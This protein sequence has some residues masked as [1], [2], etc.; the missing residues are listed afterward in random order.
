MDFVALFVGVGV[1][2]L[3]GFVIATQLA[4]TRAAALQ[5]TLE[6]KAAELAGISAES[7]ALRT[8]V[9]D[10]SASEAGAR[11]AVSGLESRVQE[12]LAN[13][14]EERQRADQAQR[15]QAEALQHS[16]ALEAKLAER[17]KSV[18]EQRALLEQSKLQ[19]TDTFKATGAELLL[20]TAEDLLKRNKDQF[21]GHKQ[22]SQQ[23]LEARQKSIDAL[24]APLKEQLAKQELLVREL[25]EKR[26]GDS[27]SLAEQLKQIAG[28]QL[29]ASQAANTLSSAMRDNRQRGQWG[30]V[31]LRNVV[32]MAGMTAH[33]DFVE[34]S[35]IDGADGA[36]LRPDMIVRLPGDRVVP[37][38]SKVPM[39][40][41]LDSIDV[42]AS[43]S[44]RLARRAAH[45]SA[46]RTHVRALGSK[47]YASA[48]GGAAEL[49]VMFVPVESALIAALEYDG[50]L[51]KEALD[52]RVVITTPSTLLALLRVCA[53]QWQQASINDNARKIGEN[54]QELLERVRKFA[55]HLQ[56][57]GT[58]LDQ[59]SKAFSAAVGSYNSRL[60]P[61]VRD[62]AALASTLEHEA[63]R[64]LQDVQQSARLD[65]VAPESRAAL[66]DGS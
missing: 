58:N 52:A 3:A 47:D 66:S 32:E 59:A 31:G 38:D 29:Q 42:N 60:V 50:S 16:G 25:G 40:A 6:S 22:L 30:E 33:V 56:R 14:A 9:T 63:A 36:R 4:R 5:A 10:L 19:L 46:L 7:A 55:E 1:G 34:Q 35:S 54:A 24:V 12:L 57:V 62:T 37:I 2:A 43:D 8:K 23:E 20:K 44:D 11:T 48:L 51:F 49:T 17:D 41:Y 45:A 13:V 21:E 26:E 28:L 15:A 39:N 65:I 53:L 27:K 61:I 18:A 64:E